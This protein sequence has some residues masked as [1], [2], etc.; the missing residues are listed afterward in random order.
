[1]ALSVKKQNREN[2]LTLVKKF[3]DKIRKSGLVI[4]TRKN[5]YHQR[6]KSDQM[7]KQSALRR[8]DSTKKYEKMIKMGEFSKMK[9]R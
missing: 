9:K 1:M 8:V 3:T 7:K 5:N 4:W 6:P 2:S